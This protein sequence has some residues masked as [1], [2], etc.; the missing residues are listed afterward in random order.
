MRPILV[1]VYVILFSGAGIE[2]A[3][4]VRNLPALHSTMDVSLIFQRYTEQNKFR[5]KFPPVGFESTNS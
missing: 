4:A 3:C 1:F 5:Q 2:F